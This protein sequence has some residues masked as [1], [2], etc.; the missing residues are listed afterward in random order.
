MTLT[1]KIYVDLYES[2]RSGNHKTLSKLYT[3]QNGVSLIYAMDRDT[4]TRALYFQILDDDL[5]SL[6]K[7]QGLSVDRVHLFEYSQVDYYCQLSQS[8]AQEDYIY[9]VIVEDIRKNAEMVADEQ[10]LFQCVSK[11]LMKW[12]AFFA[13]EKTVVLSPERQQG[14]YGELLF[15]KQLVQLNGCPAVSNWAG[16]DYE[17]HDFYIR[18]DAYEIKTTS[19]KAPYKM[20]ISSEYQLDDSDV[21][22]DLYVDFFVLRKSITD[23][24]T[25]PELIEELKVLFD[26]Y[27]LQRK[28][29]D[30]GLEKYG[31]YYGLEDKYK[32]GYHIRE[33][34][35]YK[36]CE[37]FPR[38]ISKD[39]TDGVSR[40]TYD[41]S[42]GNC[43]HFE[44]SEDAKKQKMK[45][46]D[47]NAR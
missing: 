39:I 6:P 30:E 17:T 47:T 33:E 21:K 4:D 1:H 3:T 15:L 46:S 31:Y 44:I 12:K 42:A 38:I 26:N 22:G 34:H 2:L 7:C 14:L 45:G 28:L 25:L 37:G 41:V 19:A 5:D 20:H 27:P 8:N 36:I 35:I 32:T 18:G 16:Y 24:Q 10:R 11:V 13:Q 23:G 29:F 40:C 43:V 9:E